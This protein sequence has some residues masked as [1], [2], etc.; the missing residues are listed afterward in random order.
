[1]NVMVT[2]GRGLLGTAV[3]EELKK[4]KIQYVAV[5]KKEFDITDKEKTLREIEKLHPDVIIHCAAYTKVDMAEVEQCECQRINVIGTNNI[6]QACKKLK[7]ILL[8]VSTD[9][10]FDGKKDDVYEVNDM[11]N[12]I[13]FYGKTKLEAEN[14]IQK[15]LEKFFIVRISWLFGNNGVNFVKTMLRIAEE[16]K[17]LDVVND[18]VGS[19]TYS[20]DVAK[21]FVTM[22]K[23]N[24]Y[25]VYHATNEG[26]CSWAEYAEEI[27]RIVGKDVRI[28]KITSEE[29]N[30]KAKRPKN[31]KLSKKSLTDNGFDLLPTWKDAV[32]KYIVTN[33]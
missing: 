13:N 4:N 8:F 19:P 23:T 24:K 22:V 1:M 3:C 27:F 20:K 16:K 28:K 32:K 9:Y 15:E 14:I 31:S 10:I 33:F 17:E 2:G 12:P 29:Y 6:V 11:P 30:S 7:C 5:D 21:L 26:F 25:G 18:Q